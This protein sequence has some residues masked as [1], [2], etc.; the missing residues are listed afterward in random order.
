LNAPDWCDEN[1][2][3]QGKVFVAQSLICFGCLARKLLD[4]GSLAFSL[5]ILQEHPS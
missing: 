1:F 5:D 2:T 3:Q 4:S